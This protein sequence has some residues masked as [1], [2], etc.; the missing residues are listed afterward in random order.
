MPAQRHWAV[1]RPTTAV[2]YSSGCYAKQAAAYWPAACC[3]AWARF[4]KRVTVVTGRFTLCTTCTGETRGVGS[5]CSPLICS[6]V[7]PAVTVADGTIAYGIWRLIWQMSAGI[8]S[9]CA[10]EGSSVSGSITNNTGTLLFGITMIPVSVARI[11]DGVISI[12]YNHDYSCI[13]HLL[14]D[15]WWSA[16]RSMAKDYYLVCMIDPSKTKMS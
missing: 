7:V 11:Y 5:I 12:Q 4:V 2:V 3:P 13:L 1:K 15:S 8:P 9:S 14:H 16:T 6:I 10:V